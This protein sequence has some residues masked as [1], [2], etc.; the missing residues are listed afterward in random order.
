MSG[1]T[2]Y[3]PG[4]SGVRAEDLVAGLPDS[5][6]AVFRGHVPAFRGC[7]SGPDGGKGQA[8]KAIERGNG[9]FPDKQD[10]IDTGDGY[11]LGWDRDAKPRPADLERPKMITGYDVELG[12][13]NLWQIPSVTFVERKVTFRNGRWQ[14]GVVI[15][16]L[17]ALVEAADRVLEGQEI[18]ERDGKTYFKAD[19]AEMAE[20]AATA[21]AA[22]YCVGPHE[23]AALELLSSRNLWGICQALTDMPQMIQRWKD[24]AEG[25]DG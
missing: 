4:L 20:I 24:S 1:F 12:D 17:A 13:G 21:L 25:T 8:V 22:N 7:E 11:W 3:V 23:I 10:W 14:N 19:A 15:P 5:L 16:E 2:Y 6:R 18:E 9:Y